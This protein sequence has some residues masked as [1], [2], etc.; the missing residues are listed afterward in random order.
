MRYGTLACVLSLLTTACA[1]PEVNYNSTALFNDEFSY[2]GPI[3]TVKQLLGSAPDSVQQEDKFYVAMEV[4]F[5]ADQ[6]AK[7]PLTSAGLQDA[8]SMWMSKVPVRMGVF[9]QD[10]A[11]PVVIPFM[12]FGPINYLDRPGIVEILMDDIQAPPYNMPPEYLGVWI[13]SEKKLYLDADTLEINPA[14]A[15]SVALHE[16]GHMMGLPHIAGYDEPAKT[17]TVIIGPG[18]DAESFVMYYM[19]VPGKPQNVLSQIEIDVA[20]HHLL[21]LVASLGYRKINDSCFLTRGPS[22]GI[23]HVEDSSR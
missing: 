1:Q 14:Q 5:H 11:P 23:V 4:V 18:Q 10:S 22:A 21:H 17:G 2:I 20:R 15:Y 6:A 7:Y 3:A 16:L 9:I 19:S 8:I 13:P 12:P